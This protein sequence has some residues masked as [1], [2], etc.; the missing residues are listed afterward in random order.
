MTTRIHSDLLPIITRF[1]TDVLP[2]ANRLTRWHDEL[3][4]SITGAESQPI[5]GDDFAIHWTSVASRQLCIGTGSFSNIRNDRGHAL[6]SDGDDDFTLFVMEHGEGQ[7]EHNGH[8]AILRPGDMMLTTHGMPILS[9]WSASTVMAVRIQRASITSMTPSNILGQK[10]TCDVPMVQLLSAYL[11]ATRDTALSSGTLANITQRQIIELV[12]TLTPRSNND[13]GRSQALAAARVAAMREVMANRFR[14]PDLSMRDVASAVG[15]SERSGYLA[16]TTC[17]LVFSE[18]LSALRL[19]RAKEMISS[20]I[21]MR[22]VDIAFACGF[23]DLS[24]FNRSFRAKYD[25]TPTEVRQR[26]AEQ[27]RR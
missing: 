12:Q 11:R 6:L 23:G 16:F 26:L 22:I 2:I 8:R 10:M 25:A 5:D 21:Q 15:I 18:L 19:D 13:F 20:S 14:D 24:H 17:S 3:G 4:R 27:S 9:A 7:V 1:S